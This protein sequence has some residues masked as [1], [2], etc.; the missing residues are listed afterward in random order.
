MGEKTLGFEMGNMAL[1]RSFVDDTLFTNHL[2]LSSR[3]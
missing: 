1:W 3:L 2:K